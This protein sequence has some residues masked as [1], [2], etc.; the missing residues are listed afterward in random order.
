MN[1]V[2]DNY[3]LQIEKEDSYQDNIDK[4]MSIYDDFLIARDLYDANQE[5]ITYPLRQNIDVNG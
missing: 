5:I 1:N 2:F 4:M 3:L